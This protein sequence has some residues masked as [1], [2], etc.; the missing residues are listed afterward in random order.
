[1]KAYTG[2]VVA[3]KMVKTVVIERI[4]TRRSPLYKKILRRR[5]RL[6]AHSETP[7]AIGDVVTIVSSRPISK[8][9]H[10]QVV[11]KNDIKTN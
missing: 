6:K 9:V 4:I 5:R 7:H 11:E 10:F 2:T 1:M 8:D 3:N